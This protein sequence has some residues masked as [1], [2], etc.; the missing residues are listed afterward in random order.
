MVNLHEVKN[1][2][3]SIRIRTRNLPLASTD[4]LPTYQQRHQFIYVTFK[5]NEW[6]KKDERTNE[7]TNERYN[8][9]MGRS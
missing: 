9:W 3:Y 4:S 5:V 8:E 2:F 1:K 7:H 6:T